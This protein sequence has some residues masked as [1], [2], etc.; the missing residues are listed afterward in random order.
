M[1]K[2]ALG[3]EIVIG[4]RYGYTICKNGIITV[5]RGIADSLSE[6]KITLKDI[7]EAFGCYG[8]PGEFKPEKR[9][10]STYGCNLFPIYEKVELT[11][12]QRIKLNNFVNEEAIL[13]ELPNGTIYLRKKLE[14]NSI[15]KYALK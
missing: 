15:P 5:V 14:E 2:D 1:T 7:E 13:A 6:K 12:E 4:Q 3:N 10:R 9:K 11:L 8:E